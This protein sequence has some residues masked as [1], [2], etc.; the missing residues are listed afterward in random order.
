M[1][2]Q[3]KSRE[4]NHPGH[5]DED[6]IKTSNRGVKTL[7]PGVFS[8]IVCFIFAKVWAQELSASPFQKG[9]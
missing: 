1:S 5:S 4:V 6:H 8:L 9:I 3:R 7:T 2:K